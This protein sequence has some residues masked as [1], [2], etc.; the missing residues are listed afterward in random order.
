MKEIKFIFKQ[1]W[2]KDPF[3]YFIIIAYAILNGILPFVWI[4]APAYIIKNK[5]NNLEFFLLFFVGLFLVTSIIRFLSSFLIG[6]YR[7]RMNRIRYSL[8][9]KVISY[10]LNLSYKD[11][12]DKKIK[13]TITEANRA[14]EYPFDGFGGIVLYM[15]QT[16]G[17]VV[18]L[19]GF[20][21]IFTKLD[22]YLVLY[23]V[24]MT[25]ATGRI[26][27]KLAFT[28][29]EYWEE[30]DHTWEQLNQLNYELKNP[31][32]KLDILMYDITSVFKKYYFGVSNFKYQKLAENNKKVLKLQ[33]AARTISL[34][35][36]IPVFIWM[37]LK[38][39]EGFLKVSEFYVLFTAVFGFILVTY[40]LSMSLADIAKNLK[41]MKPYISLKINEIKDY[42]RLDFDRF[43]IQLKDVCFRYPNTQR[44]VLDHINLNIP[45]GQS[46]ALVGENGAGKTSLAMLLA[47]LYEP[48]SGQILL[49]GKDIN[50]YNVDLKA[51]VAAVFQD[52]LLLPYTIKENVLMSGNDKS[53]NELYEKT[54]LD[55]IINKYE[56]KDEQIL[57]RTLNDDGVDISGGQKQ[58]LFL[59]RALNKESAKLLLLDEPTA[60]LDAIAERDLYEL[61]DMESKDKSSVFISH[62][63]ASTKFCDKVIYLKNGKIIEEGS[64]DELID[65]NGEY[66]ELFE[67]QAKNYKENHNA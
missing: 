46:I 7:M 9:S 62:R 53:P 2:S 32:S 6:N 13:E 42:D 38:L 15:P 64:H 24:L 14:I 25:L 58:R 52:S 57:L 40:A 29:E 17:Q 19:I 31:I 47:G 50:S 54:G 20:L 44:N 27:Y 21:W 49:N 60:Q 26:Y 10:S 45:S 66:K 51:Y 67:I 18:S 4:L 48:T 30:I 16:M 61:Y 65:L 33:V 22:W 8:N 37:I 56:K 41:F 11:Q 43:D 12:Q 5:H 34:L 28:Y 23:I 59:A 36:D 35:R 3:M 39:T 63:L 1:M 55:E